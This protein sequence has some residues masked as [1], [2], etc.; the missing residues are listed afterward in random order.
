ML[1][2]V[3]VLSSE[4]KVGSGGGEAEEE[5][6]DLKMIFTPHFKELYHLPTHLLHDGQFGDCCWSVSRCEPL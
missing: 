1:V 3:T 5:E 2:V 4:W 6:T